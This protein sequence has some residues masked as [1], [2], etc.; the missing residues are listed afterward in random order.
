MIWSIIIYKLKQQ[1]IRIIYH[2]YHSTHNSTQSTYGEKIPHLIPLV[3]NE[4]S[5]ANIIDELQCYVE[6][7]ILVSNQTCFFFFSFFEYFSFYA[8]YH[9]CNHEREMF[10]FHKK[11]ICINI[12]FVI[13][14]SYQLEFF[15]QQPS[16]MYLCKLTA[17]ALERD[18]K[19][20]R[21]N[22]YWKS[23]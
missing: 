22:V 3:H 10:D 5:L 7:F 14:F 11:K 9:F 6:T 15:L 23:F 12:I 1:K 13:S 20:E 17:K 4:M 16:R 21:R 8:H 2:T 19:C 18:R